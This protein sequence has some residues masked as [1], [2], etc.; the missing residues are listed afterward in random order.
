[1]DTN[2]SQDAAVAASEADKTN[3]LAGKEAGKEVGLEAPEAQKDTAEKGEAAT[4]LPSSGLG[5]TGWSI[6][7]LAVLC[8]CKLGVPQQCRCAC[9]TSSY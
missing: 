3:E 6:H 1:M 7:Q 2:S 9:I 8:K 5:L 4:K